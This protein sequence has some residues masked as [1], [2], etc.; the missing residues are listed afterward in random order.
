MENRRYD[1]SPITNRK[2]LKWPNDARVAFWVMPNIECF[3]IDQPIHGSHSHL[4]DVRGYS[5]RDYG[6]RVGIFRLM[7]I[8]GKHG[9][10]ASAALN[11]DVCR[12]YPAIVKEGKTHN[13]EWLGHGVTNNLRLNNYPKDEER[14]V[15]REVKEVITAATGKAPRG[16]LSPGLVETFDT[17]D[18][19]AAEGFEYLCDWGSDD[20][21]VPLRVRSGRLVS[22]PVL[23]GISDVGI[24][25]GSHHSAEEYVRVVCDQFDTLY[26]EGAQSG[27]AMALPLHPFV[28]GLPFRI[29]YLDRVLKHICSHDAVWRAT[30]G[31]IA[32]WYYQHDHEPPT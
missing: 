4:P 7:D 15:I 32:D 28:I 5:L 13:W 19:L 29:K 22:L 8:L 18:H 25:E 2:K 20:Q 26:E 12:L 1:Y 14:K 3:H 6:L 9:I 11:A 27:R 23:P 16:W 30:T 31:E 10:R 17:P 21:P 24:F